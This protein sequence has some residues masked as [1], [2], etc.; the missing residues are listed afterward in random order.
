MRKT[1]EACCT[2]KL[3]RRWRDDNKLNVQPGIRDGLA[4]WR[5]FIV[6]GA[7]RKYGKSSRVAG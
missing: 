6:K 2:Q 4:F 3:R 7:I 5:Y 1:G